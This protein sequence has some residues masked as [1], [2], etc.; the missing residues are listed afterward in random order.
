M[1]QRIDRSALVWHPAERMFDLVN[2]VPSYPAFLPW[3]VAAEVHS[4]EEADILASIEVAKGGV[5]HRFTTRNRLDAPRRIEMTLVEG[6]LT[7]LAGH[8]EF[9]ALN[10]QASKII[11]TLDFELSGR[12]AGMAVG[13]VLGQAAN[14]LVDAFCKRADQLF[15]EVRA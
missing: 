6:P 5:R 8:W 13:N 2:D 1:A 3:C 4:S 7:T 12:L 15:G 14:T 10:D 11:L 9:V